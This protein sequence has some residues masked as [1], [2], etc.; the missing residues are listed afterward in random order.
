MT[1]LGLGLVDDVHRLAEVPARRCEAE[2]SAH[3]GIAVDLHDLGVQ[4]SHRFGFPFSVRPS[5][6]SPY[7]SGSLWCM[8]SPE[9]IALIPQE[10]L[11]VLD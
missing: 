8:S 1:G 6:W 10:K 2:R 3:C 11:V 7:L 4:V 9:R 5:I